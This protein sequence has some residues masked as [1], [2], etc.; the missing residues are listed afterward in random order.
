[1]RRVAL[2]V[3][4]AMTGSTAGSLAACQGS[5]NERSEGERMTSAAVSSLTTSPARDSRVHIRQVIRRRRPSYTEGFVS[6]VQL[7]FIEGQILF[8]ARYPASGGRSTVEV[9]PGRYRIGSFLRP[10]NGTCA[11]LDPA[12]D[13]CSRRMRIP[14]QRSTTVRA[15]ITVTPTDGC[16]IRLR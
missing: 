7:R 6:F 5:A 2:I 3:T 4:L 16:G 9:P 10:C 14:T 15:D 12:V 8:R 13:R 1:M 11:R